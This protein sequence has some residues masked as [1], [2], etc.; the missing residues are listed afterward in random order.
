MNHSEY[1][2]ISCTSKKVSTNDMKFGKNVD[3]A[4]TVYSLSVRFMPGLHMGSLTCESG[5]RVVK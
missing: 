2:I 4:L 1:K 3:P 5:I